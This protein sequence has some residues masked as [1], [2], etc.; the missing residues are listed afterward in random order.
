[1]G[2]EHRAAKVSLVNGLS[3]ILMLLFQLV[4][5]PVCLRYWG[6][7]SYGG[8]LALFSTFSILRSLDGG[9]VAFVGNKL[10]YLYHKD[11]PALRAHLS[12][13]LIG[14]LLIGSLQLG[15]AVAAVLFEPL[16]AALGLNSVLGADRQAQM[17]LLLLMISWV[18]TG[19]YLG[20]VHRLMIPAGMMYQ[21]AWWAMAFQI[22]QFAAIMVAA[23]LKLGMLGTSVLFALSQAVNYAA[24]GIYLRWKLP[25][26]YP[27]LT[28]IDRQLG[29]QDLAS[30]SLLTGSNVIQQGAFN[31]VVLM[32]SVLAGP[33]AV[34][35]FTTI[36]TLSNL[37]TSVTTVLTTP[38]LPEV[39][40]IY[41][42]GEILKLAALNEAFWVIVGTAVN[43]GA[44]LSFPLIPFLYGLWTSHAVALDKPLLCLMLASVVVANAGALMT[45]HLNG[46]NSL[47]IILTASIIRAVLVLGCGGLGYRFWGLASFGIGILAGELLASLLSAR[48]FVKHELAGAG[49]GL[50]WTAFGPVVLSTGSVLAY[51][52]G[53]AFEWWT[54][55][56]GWLIAASGVV[57]AAVWGW[58]VLDP[59]LRSRLAGMALRFSPTS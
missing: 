46:I 59:G 21:A 39:V 58:N 5:V 25:R 57:A 10:N 35:V 33:T 29:L 17:G 31:G 38:L 34:P 49:V 52:V 11:T 23:M 19:S 14:I 6:K 1:M 20:I 27:W 15:L 2:I 16:G 13:A 55:S 56:S 36:R 9:F 40:R 26:F 53:S 47:R 3:T 28:R 41:A 4:S 50:S 18:L 42:R 54:G 48:H 37:W 51:F 8:W 44:L 24:S 7:Q 45:L 22:T 43:L 32:I 12:S 30:S